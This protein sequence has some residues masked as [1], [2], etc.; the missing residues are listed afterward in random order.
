MIT[1]IKR[2]LKIHSRN[3][4]GILF[5][6]LS[7]I[8]VLLI[9]MVFMQDSMVNSVM[10]QAPQ[11]SREQVSRLISCWLMA[12]VLSI[13]PVT[14]SCGVLVF[15]VDDRVKKIIKDFKSSPLKKY[16]YPLGMILSS[17]IFS[18]IVTI[19]MS[20]VY[21]IYVCAR[22]GFWFTAMQWILTVGVIAL[23]SIVSACVNGC[24]LC[25]VAT[26][27]AFSSFSIILG[28]TIGFFNGIYIP[29]GSLPVVVRRIIQ[30]FPYG[31]AAAFLRDILCKDALAAVF[32]GAPGSAMTDFRE[33]FGIDY[34][35]GE[36]LIPHP[37]LLLY[38]AVFGIVGF[39]IFIRW[40]SA[41]Q[42]SY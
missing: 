21:G 12:G 11:S 8:I 4:T 37:Y 17:A 42:E 30:I 39:I 3:R 18:F 16:D 27:S 40:F 6:F 28:T 36:K 14:T 15:M 7:V 19:M 2:T 5:S 29:L 24:I 34:V 32:Q 25:R 23:I 22:T 20:V 38:M 10:Q 35:I 1:I 26:E 31:G 13:T 9:C 33:Y 41:T